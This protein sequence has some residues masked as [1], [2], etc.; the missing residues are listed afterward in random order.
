[1]KI[2]NALFV[3]PR[4]AYSNSAYLLLSLHYKLN[5]RKECGKY[6]IPFTL[7]RDLSY[8]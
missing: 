2:N 5:Q 8:N 1:M 4:A 7:I 3:G 6:R